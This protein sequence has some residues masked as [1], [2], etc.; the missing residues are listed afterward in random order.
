MK[1]YMTGVILIG[2]V[3]MGLFATEELIV[4]RTSRR[5]NTI[6]VLREDVCQLFADFTAQVP[7]LLR[8]VADVQDVGVQCIRDVVS[9]EGAALEYA[10]KEQLERIRAQLKEVIQKAQ[11]LTTS[12]G[13]VH[14]VASK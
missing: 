13:T 2:G 8:A 5:D 11:E 12:L 1:K 9:A 3:F 6:G 4:P 10:S 7:K 14:R